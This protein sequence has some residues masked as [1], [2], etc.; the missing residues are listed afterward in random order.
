MFEQVIGD[1]ANLFFIIIAL[2]VGFAA[3]MSYV[4]NLKTKKNEDK[5]PLE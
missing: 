1:G 5:R 4:D 3:G 2:V